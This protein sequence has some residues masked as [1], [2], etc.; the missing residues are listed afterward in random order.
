MAQLYSCWDSNVLLVQKA[1]VNS[2]MPFSYVC[3]REYLFVAGE[4][5]AG[6]WWYVTTAGFLMP[7]YAHKYLLAISLSEQ[8]LIQN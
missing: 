1:G 2:S 4:C 3:G 7:L 8:F 6:P 5:D